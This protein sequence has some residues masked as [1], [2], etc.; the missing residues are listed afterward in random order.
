MISIIREKLIS[1]L[2]KWRYL[3]D[4]IHYFIEI[5]Q[6][7]KPIFYKKIQLTDIDSPPERT[8][9]LSKE[10]SFESVEINKFIDLTKKTL[11]SL[12]KVKS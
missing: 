2:E 6:D 7:K 8:K 12:F 4:N 5:N 1:S 3:I 11:D 10:Y 9:Y